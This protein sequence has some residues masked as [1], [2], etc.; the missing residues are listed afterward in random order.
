M[1]RRNINWNTGEK[2]INKDP[3]IHIQTVFE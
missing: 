1:P 3:I 2:I